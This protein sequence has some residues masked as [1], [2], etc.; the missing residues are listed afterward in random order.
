MQ[1]TN[2]EQDALLHPDEGYT[3]TA[4]QLLPYRILN[5]I[6]YVIVIVMNALSSVGGLNGNTQGNISD[7]YPNSF[8]PAGWAFS[9]WGPIYIWLGAFCIYTAVLP[10]S[11]D[12]AKIL[13]GVGPWFIISCIFNIAWIVTFIFATPLAVSISTIWL[14][15][16]LASLLVIVVKTDSWRSVRTSLWDFWIVDV[17]FSMYA[18]WCTV[19]SIAN[20]VIS[21][22]GG[23]GWDGSPWNAEGWSAL[24]IGVAA[25]INIAVLASRTDAVF[26]LVFCWAAAAIA[27]KHQS[28]RAVFLTGTIC[29][30][31]IGAG[32]LGVIVF[33]IV[34]WAKRLRNRGKHTSS[35]NGSGSDTIDNK[36][37]FTGP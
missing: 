18:G 25:A 29:S 21:L 28:E 34:R 15:L 8:V 7:S 22:S 2:S 31:V 17:A 30:A 5:P 20:V 35:S 33:H 37:T 13:T 9:I 24:M 27:D 12:A 19:A 14:F 26:A 3:K 6:F 16:L 4:R 23:L 1:T 11:T 32:A 36:Y 10:K